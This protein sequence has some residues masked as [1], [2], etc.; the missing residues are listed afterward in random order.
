MSCLLLP[1]LRAV[2]R[3][4][5]LDENVG[6]WITGVVVLVLIIILMPKTNMWQY[7]WRR[8]INKGNW[9]FLILI[10][11]L[12]VFNIPYLFYTT[13]FTPVYVAL[14]TSAFVGF[15][16]ELAFRGYLYRA[17][18][19]KLGEGKAIMLSAVVFGLMHL[20]NL[21]HSSVQ[22]VLLQVLYTFAIGVAFA[23]VRS[24]T[25]S[26][27]WPVIAHAAMNFGCDLTMDEI[28]IVWSDTLAT[29]YC[30]AL[31]AIYWI[32][33]VKGNKHENAFRKHD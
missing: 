26:L 15:A 33:Y 16:E 29:I 21:T 2:S 18:E 17:L 5:G 13:A 11:L 25:K 9:K 30:V 20:I 6:F 10:L 1:F 8:S 31:A 19:I 4:I 27:L 14:F 23:V 12:G 24:K 28:T 7:G 3:K 22:D 32:C